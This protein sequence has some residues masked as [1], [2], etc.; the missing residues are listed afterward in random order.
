[1]AVQ[2]TEG[3]GDAK[4]RWHASG[5]VTR[6]GQAYTGAVRV[7][8]HIFG[9]AHK[10]VGRSP[11]LLAVGQHV[12]SWMGGSFGSGAESSTFGLEI[13]GQI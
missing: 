7:G 4:V 10:G 13:V 11:K 3:R 8:H 2:R 6:M 9:E 5:G 1:M 12:A